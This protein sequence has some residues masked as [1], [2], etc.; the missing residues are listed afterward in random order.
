MK[1]SNESLGKIKLVG[2]TVRTSN[3]L[4]SNPETAKIGQQ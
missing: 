2:I 3:S 1:K 4:E